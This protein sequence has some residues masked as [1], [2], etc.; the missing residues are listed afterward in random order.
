MSTINHLR[1]KSRQTW[2]ILVLLTVLMLILSSCSTKTAKVHRVGIICGAKT[3]ISIGDS[4]RERMTE[5]QYIEGKNILYDIQ[6]TDMN[7]TA[8]RKAINKFVGDKVDLILTFPTT[9]SKSAKEATQG[10]D[11]PVVFTFSTIEGNNLV[12]SV[13]EPGGNITGVRFPGPDLVAKRFEFLLQLAPHVKRVW[14]TY[15]KNYPTTKTSLE[16]LRPL[17]ASSGISVVEVPAASIAGI[18]NDFQVRAKLKDIG[19]DAILILPELLSQSQEAWAVISRFAADYKLPI[20]GS[21]AFEADQGALFTYIPDYV[22]F[23]RSAA[24]LA[25]KVLKGIPAGSIPVITPESRLRLNYRVAQKL[26][27]K[28]PKGT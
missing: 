12:K 6:K 23:G 27:L 21:E 25:D 9:A 11:I 17:A 28:I 16:V 10:T 15:E 8:E 18:K 3:L 19:I 7:P 26:G 2:T 4:F 1:K 14:V 22:E 24:V 20:A 13:R 5:L